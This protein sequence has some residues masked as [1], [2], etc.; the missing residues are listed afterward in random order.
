MLMNHCTP[1]NLS[2]IGRMGTMLVPLP[3]WKVTRS[4]T[5]IRRMEIM[6]TGSAMKNQTPQL[7]WG[8]MFWRAIMFCGEAMGEAAPPMLEARAMPR[9]RALEKSESE[10]RLRRRGLNFTLAKWMVE[11]RYDVPV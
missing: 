5:Q 11:R 9:I 8:R 4:N 2:F 1:V 10:G 6:Q 3:G 7:G